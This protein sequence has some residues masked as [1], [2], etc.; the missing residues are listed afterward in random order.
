MIK[1][2]AP[3]PLQG[4]NRVWLGITFQGDFLTKIT[5]RSHRSHP[6]CEGNPNIPTPTGQQW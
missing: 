1:P 6:W 3:A 2:Y 4:A 5:L